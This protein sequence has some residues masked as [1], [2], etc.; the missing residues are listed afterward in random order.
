VHKQR[1][2]RLRAIAKERGID[3]LLVTHV[4]NVFYLTG[5]TGSTAAAVVTPERCIILV[6]P[7]YTSQARMECADAEVEEFRGKHTI[8]AISEKINELGPGRLGYEGD[9]LTVRSYRKMRYTF[10]SNVRLKSVSG[11]V[12]SLRSIKDGHEIA[13]IKRAAEILDTSFDHLVSEIKVGMTERE[14]GILVDTTVR[15][16]GADKEGFETIAA[17]GPNSAFPHASP[18]DTSIAP[19]GFLKLDFGARLAKY[20][21]DITRTL[22]IGEPSQQQQHIY[23]TVLDAQMKAIEAIR[24]G[25]TGREI[26]SVARDYITSAGYGAHFGHGLG[27][28]L[29]IA[30]HDG[31]AF[32]AMSKITLEPGMVATVEPGIYIEGW[33]G[34]RIED[35]IVVTETGADVI[36]HATKELLVIA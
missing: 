35:D 14:V 19:G 32:S 16:L 23:R 18:T 2:A 29:G 1:L 8:E 20:N 4:D 21:A 10:R 36:T 24:P 27:H 22:S 7:R 3:A 12:E 6:D 34:V 15:R 30:V 13:L 5:F 9:H 11:M 33:G 28:A 17:F 26:D 31:P 25:R